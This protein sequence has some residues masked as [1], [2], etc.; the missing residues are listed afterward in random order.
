MAATH[1]AKTSTDK[2][3]IL[4]AL[5]TIYIVW[6]TTYLAIR[7]G[8]ES[9]PPFLMIGTRFLFAGTILFV[10]LRVRKTAPPSR[11][12][13]K[14]AAIIGIFLLGG[15]G[16]MT[17]FAEQWITSGIAAIGIATVPL[18]AA[19]FGGLFGSWPTRIEWLGITVGFLGVA[20][21]SLDDNLQANPIGAIAI[22]MAAASWAFGSILSQRLSLPSGPM[23]F[24]AEMLAGGGFLIVLGTLRGERISAVPST[25]AALAW[26]YLVFIGSLVAFSAYMYLLARVRPALATSYAYVNPMVAVLL[27]SALA[28]EQITVYGLIGMAVILTSVGVISFGRSRE[29]KD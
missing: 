21:L 29:S 4:L 15:G 2:Y 22:L 8:L 16:G 3:G 25:Q 11:P 24:A 19:I 1:P 14:H 9:F 5:I 27:G 28:D 18:W 23:G 10:F 13:W 26:I 20:A 12:Q 7:I 6:G 17:A